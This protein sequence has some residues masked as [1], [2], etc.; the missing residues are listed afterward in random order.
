MTDLID[1]IVRIDT[2][3]ALFMNEH[4]TNSAV[5]WFFNFFT[6]IGTGGICWMLVFLIISVTRK[7]KRVWLY[8][9]IPF[10]LVFLLSELGLKHLVARP[11]PYIALE[12]IHM[13]AGRINSY[14]FPSSHSAFSGA[15]V[16]IAARIMA[17]PNVIPYFV[18]SVLVAASRV[19]LKAHFLSDVI[20]G[21]VIG[22]L[23]TLAVLK[24]LGYYFRK[25]RNEMIT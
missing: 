21:Y 1:F 6:I 4:I 23:I 14:S 9:I 25:N 7:Q 13:L 18:I 2:S 20:C 19:V 3:V 15:A 10:T 24:I 12:G 17:P 8:W 5:L 11:R 16:L 22:M